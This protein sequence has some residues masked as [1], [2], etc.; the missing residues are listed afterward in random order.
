MTPNQALG[1]DGFN[2]LF[3]KRCWHLIA[4][5]FC[6]LCNEFCENQLDIQSIN[7]SLITLVPKKLNPETVNDFWPISLLN[8]SLK[9][10]TKLA[11]E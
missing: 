9:L 8:S 11:S 10:L 7:S 5:D 4:N 3:M 1:P 6:H 2:G